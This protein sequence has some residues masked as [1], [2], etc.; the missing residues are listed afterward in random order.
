MRRTTSKCRSA[1][2]WMK[3]LAIRQFIREN[4]H[5]IDLAILRYTGRTPGKDRLN[6]E[7][8]RGWIMNDEGLYQWA[9]REGV[10]L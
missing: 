9:K 4:R 7:E 6:D 1:C 2:E 10:A 8:R 3:R 5:A